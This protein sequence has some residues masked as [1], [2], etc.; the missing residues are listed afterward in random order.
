M[1][2]TTFL[3]PAVQSR[4]DQRSCYDYSGILDFKL[5]AGTEG[6][7]GELDG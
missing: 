2:L 1:L 3:L 4:E 6:G 7:M 5:E